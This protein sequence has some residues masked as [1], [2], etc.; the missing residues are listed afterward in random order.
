MQYVST[1]S[2]AIAKDKDGGND[3]EGPWRFKCVDRATIKQLCPWW[4]NVRR[5]SKPRG[6]LAGDWRAGW[7]CRKIGGGLV[8]ERVSS[9]TRD[10]N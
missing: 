4:C 3:A 8:V 7:I 5:R 9:L 1:P 2:D 10:I 6:S